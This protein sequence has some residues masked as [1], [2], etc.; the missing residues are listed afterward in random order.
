MRPPASPILLEG[1]DAACGRFFP[2]FGI[3]NSRDL[4]LLHSEH[5]SH[6][7][8]A[9]VLHGPACACGG[10]DGAISSD[11]QFRYFGTESCACYDIGERNDFT[12]DPVYPCRSGTEP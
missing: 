11:P 5:V 12:A 2:S 8:S 6:T 9:G 4:T 7:T 3:A 10:R 1:Y